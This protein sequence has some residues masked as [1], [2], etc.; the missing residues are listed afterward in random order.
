MTAQRDLEDEQRF[1]D[2][3]YLGLEAMRADAN[4]MLESVLD[5]GRGGTF[6]SRTE[7]DIVVRTSLARLAQL[8]IGDQALCFGRIDR[9]PEPGQRVGDTFH[10]G[11]LAVSGPDHEPLV[12][13]W[14][15]PVAEPFYRATGLDPQGL[16]R[17]RHLA[18]R[19]RTVVGVEDEYFARLGDGNAAP[20]GSAAAGTGSGDGA[21]EAGSGGDGDGEGLAD[22]SL[23][24]GGPGAL[25][26]ALGQA[27]TGQMGDI[28]ATIQR[29][30]DEIIR[31]P[32]AGVLMVQGGPG[33]GKTAVALHRAA[34]LLYTHR[35]PLER[36]GVLVVGPNPLF[37]RYIEQVLPSLGETGVTLST[38]PGL[39]PEVRVRAAEAADVARLKGDARMVRVIARAVRT[40]QRPLRRDVA[41]PFGAATLR[42]TAADSAGIV[43]LA[44]R[45]PGPHNARRRFVE[46]QVVRRLA[47]QYR[48]FR[49]DLGV[50]VAATTPDHQAAPGPAAEPTADLLDLDRGRGRPTGQLAL[51]GP[52]PDDTT[53]DGTGDSTG[54]D[55][56]GTAAG[57][58][59]ADVVPM[60]GVFGPGG[61]GPGGS[62][63]GG[64]GPG[65]SRPDVSA[66]TSGTS[67]ETSGVVGTS[68]VAGTSGVTGARFDAVLPPAEAT[69]DED[70]D[71][72]EFGRS[73]RRV[74]ELAEALD[75]MW[76]RLAPH[77]LLHD[78]FGARPLLAAAGEGVLSPAEQAS[79]YRPRSRSL[80]QVPWTAA[81]AALVDEARAVLGP[82]RSRSR[83]SRPDNRERMERAREEV[84]YWPSGLDTTPA[85]AAG[86]GGADEDAV[87]S[88]GHIV[89]DEIQDLSPLQLRMLARRS[90]SGSMTV[91]GDIAQ[92]TGPWAPSGWD[93]VARHLTPS[94]E[95][96]LVELTVSYRT[97]AEVV[98]VAAGVLAVAAPELTPPRPVRRS[99]NRPTLTWAPPG[100]LARRVA[101][102]AV[103]ESAAVAPGRTAV[104]VPAA[105]F[106]E[107]REA[108]DDLGTGA[109]DPRDPRGAG[110][111]A[112][113]V[114]LPADEANGLEFD[115]VVVVEPAV[116]AAGDQQPGPARSLG[117]EAPPA[118]TTRGLR[119]LYVALT[120][121]T[122]RLAVVHSMPLPIGLSLD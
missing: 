84:G 122:R 73:V 38:V 67:A 110:L 89:V 46:Q 29:E 60:P 25:L 108:L 77:E 105:R 50:P 81:D 106:Q 116:L 8:D 80:E 28:V 19:G 103:A 9:L 2:Q 93:E 115:A 118:P 7:R 43:G 85:P 62:G 120:R 114:V 68:G 30:Q 63:T 113:L 36:Q 42:L 11:R 101:E 5:L 21:G 66:E 41:V 65:T 112:P 35:F 92:A 64:S 82:R 75:R 96:R 6:Q 109:V 72:D 40:R 17:R 98:A 22:D 111:S 88:Y 100:A 94:R 47:D 83:R 49:R 31:S 3:A 59:L 33:T 97:P 18:V 4:R 45:R 121:P 117:Q 57:G 44:R 32:L 15:A 87:R 86:T 26:A 55:G 12:V 48:R 13:D 54:G 70:F 79:L 99:G 69:P 95:P 119:A 61:S 39:V 71:V 20:D 56:D 1:L 14:R 107:V 34:Y 74:P 104:L 52:D 91:V 51:F 24:L 90:L 27:R 76:P 58:R 78:L 37:L 23:P 102:V 16:A 53:D 10:I